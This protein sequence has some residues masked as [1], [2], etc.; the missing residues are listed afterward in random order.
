MPK[1]IPPPTEIVITTQEKAFYEACIYIQSI[2]NKFEYFKIV[3]KHLPVG[4]AVYG[5]LA[6]ERKKL[7]YDS[8]DE[9]SRKGGD[10]I[11][12]VKDGRI[13]EQ[14]Q[15]MTLNYEY[16]FLLIEGSPNEVEADR[17]LKAIYT[18]LA[19]IELRYNIRHQWCKDID[20]L[21]YY[22]LALC[23]K[24]AKKVKPKWHVSRIIP[25]IEDEKESVLRGIKGIGKD[26]ARKAL[27]QFKSLK[28]VFNASFDE[29]KALDPRFPANHLKEVFESEDITP[30]EIKVKTIKVENDE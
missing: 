20:F 19:D 17:D 28:K 14:A 13:F 3:K 29:L 9:R 24:L 18:T 27:T 6:V 4:D 2:T 5:N 16:V 7:K 8:A 30:E 1:I 26:F 25:R 15:N 11:A 12:S 10:F 21:A 22:F 23:F